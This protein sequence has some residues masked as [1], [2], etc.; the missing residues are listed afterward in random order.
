MSLKLLNP[1]LL[2]ATI[3]SFIV[4]IIQNL[5]PIITGDAAIFYYQVFEKSLNGEVLGVN[6]D[7]I[8]PAAAQIPIF[9]AGMIGK[10]FGSYI[11]GW[12][13]LVA[14]L[15]FIVVLLMSKKYDISHFQM[16]YFSIL[17]IVTSSI[18]YY[19]LDIIAIFLSL[20]ALMIYDKKRNLSYLLLTV[21]T[22]IKIWPIAIIFG[23]WL[24]SKTKVMDA[25]KVAFYATLLMAPALILGGFETAFHFISK[26]GG[27][28]VQM[29][30]IFALPSFLSGR[31][32][33]Y[34]KDTITYEVPIAGFEFLSNLSTFL[35][36]GT[37]ISVVLVGIVSFWK[38]PATKE[39]ALILASMIIVSFVIFNKVGSAQFVGWVILVLFIL[40]ILIKD[41]L[42]KTYAILGLISI[43]ASGLLVP[44]F[45]SDLITGGLLA[46]TILS[47]KH[48]S[49]GIILILLFY[50]FSNSK[51]KQDLAERTN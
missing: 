28:G 18:F 36:I 25:A 46:V 8:Y 23:I 45:Y 12:T 3:T 29:E 30:S 31:E 9:L 11:L 7:W 48:V 26:Q 22:L 1:P 15:N 43:S 10:I 51:N 19:R 14:I 2:W 27:R 49:L 42:G 16:G 34:N 20:I 50:S 40:I 39:Q 32:A 24:M 44:Y 41:K 35:L 5:S 17:L 37:L 47:V 38:K 33:F 21:G 13:M 6:A 4:I